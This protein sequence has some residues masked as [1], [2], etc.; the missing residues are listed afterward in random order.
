MHIIYQNKNVCCGGWLYIHI[1]INNSICS[2]VTL[3][4]VISNTCVLWLIY[5]CMQMC[6]CITCSGY[7]YRIACMVSNETCAVQA[8]FPFLKSCKL[9]YLNLALY[10]TIGRG[11]IESGSMLVNILYTLFSSFAYTVHKTSYDT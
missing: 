7:A 10:A 4:E 8:I 9:D 2:F 1:L 11:P 5:P 6:M 3:S